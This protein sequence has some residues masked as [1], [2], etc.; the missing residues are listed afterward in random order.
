[1]NRR[2]VAV[3]RSIGR[4]LPTLR[5]DP[6]AEISLRVHESDADERQAK[7]AGLFTMVSG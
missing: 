6:L 7:V 5:R 2:F 1:M 3:E 4:L